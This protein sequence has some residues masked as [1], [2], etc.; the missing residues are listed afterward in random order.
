MTGLP[1]HSLMPLEDA[2]T[3]FKKVGHDVSTLSRPEFRAAYYGLARK[4]QSNPAAQDLM[5]TINAAKASI[6]GLYDWANQSDAAAKIERL[7]REAGGGA[8]AAGKPNTAPLRD[9]VRAA[10]AEQAYLGTRRVIE[11]IMQRR[12][13][14]RE[15]SVMERMKTA[16]MSA[17]R[18]S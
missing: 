2:L 12:R 9:I 4:Y 16:L 3:V 18:R 10:M 1:T 13:Q 15:L 8:A 14:R 11:Q 6:M 7:R 17:L 5:A